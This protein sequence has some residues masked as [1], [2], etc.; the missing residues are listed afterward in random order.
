MS[1]SGCKGLILQNKFITSDYE[2]MIC[3]ICPEIKDVEPGELKSKKFKNLT[4]LISMTSSEV[5]G[6]FN[7]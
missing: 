5:N 4:T 3:E 2:S 7:W 1:Q 6:I